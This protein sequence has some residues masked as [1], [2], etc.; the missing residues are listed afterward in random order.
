M[1]NAEVNTAGAPKS[2]VSS[3]VTVPGRNQTIY[4]STLVAQLNQDPNLSHDRL[5]RLRQRQEY[6]VVEE[7]VPANASMV[8][9]FDDYAVVDRRKSRYLVG[10]LVRLT[11]KGTRGSQD[12]KRPVSYNDD[13][14]KDITAFLQIYP[15]LDVPGFKFGLQSTLQS[16]PF[17]DIMCHVNLRA[18]EDGRDTLEL[19]AD[20]HS[21]LLVT[22]GRLVSSSRRTRRQPA[23]EPV[24]T[25]ESVDSA[26]RT[27]VRPPEHERE[28]GLRRSSRVRTVLWYDDE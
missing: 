1:L 24:T 26:N 23:M 9:L 22:V 8:S 25:I 3:C 14:G 12:Y 7:T 13:R 19:S 28:S 20:E 6:Q 10:N 27:V 18:T 21:A 17:R 11:H 16:V 15:R 2:T 4:K 5:T